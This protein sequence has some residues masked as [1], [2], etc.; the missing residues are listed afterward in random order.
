MK[1]VFLGIILIVSIGILSGCMVTENYD[2]M[3]ENNFT[4]QMKFLK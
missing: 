4:V 1:K 2:D 3:R